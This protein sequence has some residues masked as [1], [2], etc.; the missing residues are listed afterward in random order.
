MKGIWHKYKIWLLIGV[1]YAA[2]CAVKGFKML[3]HIDIHKVKLSANR[4]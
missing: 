2:Y 1:F 3:K 4:S